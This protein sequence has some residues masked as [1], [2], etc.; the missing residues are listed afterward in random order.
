MAVYASNGITSVAASLARLMGFSP[1]HG[2]GE[3]N[4]ALER[5]ARAAVSYTHLDVYKRQSVLRVTHAVLF[6]RIGK[7]TL[8]LLFSQTVQLSVHRLSLIHISR[9]TNTTSTTCWTA[10]ARP[11]AACSWTPAR[12]RASRTG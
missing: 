3:P 10:R 1:P 6:L 5:Y 7:H 11:A 8:N 2:A 12:A 9:T 4:L